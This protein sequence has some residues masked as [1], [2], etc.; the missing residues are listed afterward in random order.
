[1]YFINLK[2]WIVMNGGYIGDLKL[3]NKGNQRSLKTSKEISDGDILM[4]IPIRLFI[5]G[6][7]YQHKNWLTKSKTIAHILDELKNME[8]SFYKPYLKTIP[9][10]SYFNDHPLNSMNSQNIQRW[11]HINSDFIYYLT[12]LYLEYIKIKKDL[13]K[14]YDSSNLW[15]AY[16]L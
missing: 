16:L 6:S 10:P 7:K 9:K 14:L 2:K 4:N 12:Q 13:D 11:K 15:Y 3:F 1:M 5:D 8:N